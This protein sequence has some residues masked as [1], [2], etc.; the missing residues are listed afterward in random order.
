MENGELKMSLRETMKNVIGS[1]LA[2]CHLQHVYV[3]EYLSIENCIP[4]GM[5]RPVER[6]DKNQRLPAVRYAS[7]PLVH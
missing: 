5:R 1:G 6:N 3:V 2:P 7:R 4:S